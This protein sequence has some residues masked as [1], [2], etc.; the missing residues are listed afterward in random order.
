[1]KCEI[2]I[3]PTCEERVVIYSKGYDSTVEEIKRIAE[4][5]DNGIF[6]YLGSEIVRLDPGEIQYVSVIGNR[7][8]AVLSEEKYL[9]KERLYTLE[10]RLPESFVRINQSCIANITWMERFDTSISG[11]L[12]IRFKNGDV[13]YVS[14]RQLKTVKERIGI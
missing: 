11:T 14:R 6:G 7:V 4:G 5:S 12:K 2:I 9:L 1:M 10:E 13:D 3:D 8:C